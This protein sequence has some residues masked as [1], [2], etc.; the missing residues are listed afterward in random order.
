MDRRFIR[1]A[2]IIGRGNETTS[3]ADVSEKRMVKRRDDLPA[4]AFAGLTI[5]PCS[6][7][8]RATHLRLTPLG[9]RSRHA[10]TTTIVQGHRF[11]KM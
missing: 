1:L 2:H 8:I 4:D 5:P 9:P 7:M 3:A 11:H 6:K 10:A